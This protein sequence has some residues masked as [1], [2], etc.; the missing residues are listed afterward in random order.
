MS[1]KSHMTVDSLTLTYKE[2]TGDSNNRGNKYFLE[3]HYVS[4]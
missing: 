1:K 2:T 3:R 4:I